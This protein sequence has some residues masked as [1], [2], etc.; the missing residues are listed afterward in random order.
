M[1][2]DWIKQFDLDVGT[3]LGV[4]TEGPPGVFSRAYTKGVAAVHCPPSGGNYW[5]GSLPFS[6]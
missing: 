2:P 6:Y 4:C 1:V 3:P 5:S